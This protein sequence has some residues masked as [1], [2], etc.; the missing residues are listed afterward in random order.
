MPR[1]G[2]KK[3][4]EK[5]KQPVRKSKPKQPM[6]EET[7]PTMKRAPEELFAE[8]DF[9]VNEASEEADE[10][11]TKKRARKPG[12]PVSQHAKLKAAMAIRAT[13]DA[14]QK[15]RE[16]L[17]DDGQGAQ[18]VVIYGFACL[19]ETN[20]A[21]LSI[22][23][24]RFSDEELRKIRSALESI[25]AP[26]TLEAFC[27]L[28][29]LFESAIS[30][31][32]SRFEAAQSLPEYPEGQRI[33]GASRVLTDELEEKLFAFCKTHLEELAKE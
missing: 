4:G 28:Q 7:L 30:K 5:P 8:M 15:V 14:L 20:S 33:D 11:S 21:G 29:E 6:L 1:V 25:D 12:S 26:R 19:L 13:F 24:D 9:L 31:G 16:L 10:P 27:A 2:K 3:A 22:L 17:P 23:F 18:A 32:E